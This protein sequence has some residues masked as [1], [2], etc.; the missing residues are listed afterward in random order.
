MRKKYPILA[1][2]RN[3]EEKLLYH[4]YDIYLSSFGLMNH[5]KIEN[6]IINISGTKLQSEIKLYYGDNNGDIYGI[7]FNEEYKFLPVNGRTV[8]DI[9]ANIGDSS[10]YFALKNAGK[11]IAL[12][13]FPK[14][15]EVAK[16]NVEI[17]NLT[18]KIEIVLAGCFSK[19]GNITIDPKEE[20][21]GKA[22]HPSNEGIQIPL[23][24]LDDILA[25]F[26]VTQ[27]A[28][29]KIDCEG[30]EYDIILSTSKETLQKFSH[31]LIEYHYGYKNLKE[32]LEKCNFDVSVT[33]PSFMI[34]RQAKKSMYFGYLYAKQNDSSK[35]KNF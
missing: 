1:K 10:I 7:F 22:L 18:N 11:V 25:T 30:C 3:G 28:L 20:G 33:D 13:P 21:A 17:N 24:T 27:P 9:G 34:N 35:N 23:M 6:N 4:Y 14:N 5:C 15:Y 32:K 12:E 8:I 19:A 16:K 2:L 31:I 26:S 29:L